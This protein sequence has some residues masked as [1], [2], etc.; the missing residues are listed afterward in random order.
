M[1][2][3]E[4]LSEWREHAPCRGAYSVFFT[5]DD[6]PANLALPRAQRLPTR[7]ARDLCRS[8]PG[9]IFDQC[10]ADAMAVPTGS[11]DNYRADTTPEDRRRLRRG[12]PLTVRPVLGD[13]D[14]PRLVTEWP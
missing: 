8:C 9:W 1:K 4:V 14:A 11:D 10:L 7:D 12:L 6:D 13:D 2:Q 3:S 5:F